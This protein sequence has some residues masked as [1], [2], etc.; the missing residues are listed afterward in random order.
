M[1]TKDFD[2]G[3]EVPKEDHRSCEPGHETCVYGDIVGSIKGKANDT[4]DNKFDPSSSQEEVRKTLFEQRNLP[5]AQSLLQKIYEKVFESLRQKKWNDDVRKSYEEAIGFFRRW[6]S[7]MLEIKGKFQEEAVNN[8]EAELKRMQGS[9]K[10]GM[11][12]KI[13]ETS[14]VDV[15]KA[16]GILRNEYPE[17]QQLNIKSKTTSENKTLLNTGGYFE[18]PRGFD[19]QISIVVVTDNVGIEHYKKLM[20]KRKLSAEVAAKMLEIEPE[21][22]TPELLRLFIFLH[23][24]GHAYDYIKNY[25]NQK[26]GADLWTQRG[27]AE[28]SSLPIPNINPSILR[29]KID[30]NEIDDLP[31]EIQ[32]KISEGKVDEIVYDQEEAYRKLPKENFADQFAANFIKEHY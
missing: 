20:Q 12:E 23:E 5:E 27:Q 18:D 21:N 4:I 14:G 6:A 13:V 7:T 15:K 3:R 1:S 17:L 24:I 16:W 30:Q 31:I 32:K 29:H 8:L 9:L 28:T 19:S 2:Y 25:A 10:Q 22:M 26:D 11:Q